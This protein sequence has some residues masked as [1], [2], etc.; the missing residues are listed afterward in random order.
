ML[1][2]RTPKFVNFALKFCKVKEAW[3]NHVYKNWIWL[4]VSNEE[5]LAAT[6][7][8]LG[9]KKGMPR[10]FVFEDTIAWD[11]LSP[12]E[13]KEW[14]R[15]AKWVSWFQCTVPTIWDQYKD[16]K[17]KGAELIDLKRTI[18]LNWLSEYFPTTEDDAKTRKMKNKFVNE[19]ADYLIDCFENLD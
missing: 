17:Q 3:L 9:Y 12:E 16:S 11:S 18:M 2:D 7:S 13:S 14:K 10:E 4:Y 1:R 6:R 8:V 19:L 5:R 15:I